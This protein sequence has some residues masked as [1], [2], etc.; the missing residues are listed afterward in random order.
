MATIAEKLGEAAVTDSLNRNENPIAA[1]WVKMN[2][3][4]SAGRCQVGPPIGYTPDTLFAGGEDD[5]YWSTSP[6]SSSSTQFI[7]AI[8]TI[9]RVGGNE[10]QTGVW[11]C[12]DESAPVTT[13]NG[14]LLRLERKVGANEIKFTIEK[15][16]AGTPEVIKEMTTTSFIAGAK[17]ALVVGNGKAYLFAS[18]TEGGAFE[19]QMSVETATYT[20]GYSGMRAKG[21]GEFIIKDFRTGTFTLEAGEYV[22]EFTGESTWAAGSLGGASSGVH[23]RTVMVYMRYDGT[24][25]N[26]WSVSN[27]SDQ[28]KGFFPMLKVQSEDKPM[29]GS[30][31][32]PSPSFT[33]PKNL[34]LIGYSKEG[35]A[36]KT[37][38]FH[39]YDFVAKKWTHANASGTSQEEGVVGEGTNNWKRQRWGGRW[40]EETPPGLDGAIAAIAIWDSVLTDEQI[41]KL[42]SA[43]SVEDWKSLSPAPVQLTVFNKSSAGEI[44]ELVGST[45]QI[46][47]TGT[48]TTDAKPLSLPYKPSGLGKRVKVLVGGVIKEVK[49]WVLVKGEL[50]NR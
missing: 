7:Y 10:R 49:R 46:S 19:E 39:M 44:E 38:R 12:R 47:Q 48:T 1:P 14:Y 43:A 18:T 36:A 33:L 35:G 3:G 17:I 5:C 41:E 16:V 8:F 2:P 20:K 37:G 6:F 24:A 9:T 45:T 23:D 28:F 31:R 26:I 50:V 11:L 40:G 34:C 4:A 42:A 27:V 29:I 30:N 32:L 15:W 22:R 21:T 25:G 13:Q